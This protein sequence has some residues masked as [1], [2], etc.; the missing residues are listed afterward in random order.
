MVFGYAKGVKH[1][2][3]MFST[4]WVYAAFLI[5]IRGKYGPRS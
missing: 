2:L 4:F 1:W 3:T 5:P